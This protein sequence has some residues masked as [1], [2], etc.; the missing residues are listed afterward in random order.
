MGLKHA[1]TVSVTNV[2]KARAALLAVEF[3]TSVGFKAHARDY[4]TLVFRRNGYG[5][6]M[7][8]FTTFFGVPGDYDRA[9]VQ[10]TVLTQCLPDE[11]KYTLQFEMSTGG[12]LVKRG[13]F[14]AFV[15]T[16]VDGFCAFSSRWTGRG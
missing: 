5:R 3:W 13:Q 16:W 4:N 12:R 8:L 14:A 11:V 1:C 2:D 10:L 6:F 9:P 15:Q 7:F